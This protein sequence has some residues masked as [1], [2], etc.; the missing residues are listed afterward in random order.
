MGKVRCAPKDANLPANWWPE[1]LKYMAYV[2]NCAPM[3]RLINWT[4]Y[5]L[6]KGVSPDVKALQVWDS[7]CFAYVH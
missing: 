2:Q 3:S 4:P 1:A 7:V 5:E 6:V